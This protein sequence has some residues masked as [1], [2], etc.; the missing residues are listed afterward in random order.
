[1]VLLIAG[2][3][4]VA[5][6]LVYPKIVGKN[7]VPQ[8]A[9]APPVEP[10]ATP[11]DTLENQDAQ[12][13]VDDAEK[14]N[15][16]NPEPDYVAEPETPQPAVVQPVQQQQSSGG[17]KGSVGRGPFVVIVGSFTTQSRAETYGAMVGRTGVNYEVIDFGNG[18]VRVAVASY[19]DLSTARKHVITLQTNPYCNEAWV[20]RR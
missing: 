18:R 9:L 12:G 16:L 4:G 11:A 3:I 10:V 20:L 6:Y 7:D 19:D 8:V 2:G 15:A 17:T 1:V 13:V 5:A 14:K